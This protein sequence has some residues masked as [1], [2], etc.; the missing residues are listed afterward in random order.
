MIERRRKPPR[1]RF[2]WELVGLA[3]VSTI[4]TATAIMLA[5]QLF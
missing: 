1:R 5:V 2:N 4:V 3:L